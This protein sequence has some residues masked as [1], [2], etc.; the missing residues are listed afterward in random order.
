MGEAEGKAWGPATV[1]PHL[2][3]PPMLTPCRHF[4]LFVGASGGRAD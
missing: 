4:G 3:C 1:F 2:L